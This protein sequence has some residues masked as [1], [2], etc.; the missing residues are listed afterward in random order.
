MLIKV[1]WHKHYMSMKLSVIE[2]VNVQNHV[3]DYSFIK[4]RGNE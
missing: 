1:K 3:G 4:A 2:T